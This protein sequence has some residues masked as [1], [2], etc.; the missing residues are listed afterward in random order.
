MVD[1]GFVVQDLLLLETSEKMYMPPVTRGQTH[2]TK[3]KVREEQ[4]IAK[5]RIHVE[6]VI[7]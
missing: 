3:G 6:M 1:R 2:F 7:Q 4:R 5:A